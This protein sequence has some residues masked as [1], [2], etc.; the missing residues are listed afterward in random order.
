MVG[1]LGDPAEPRA[2]PGHRPRRPPR[3]WPTSARRSCACGPGSL[4]PGG[5]PRHGLGHPRPARL[6]AHAARGRAFHDGARARR[7]RRRG[8]PRAPAPRA[9]LSRA[10]PSGSG[11]TSS[12]SRSTS[13]TPPCSRRSPSP[14]SAIQSPRRLAARPTP[15]G[16][17]PFRLVVG[18]ARA[19][20]ARRLRRL[21]GRARRACGGCVFRRFASEDALAR[22]LAARRGG[23]LRRRSAPSG[24]PSCARSAA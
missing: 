10:T 13:R 8:E 15:V 11:R 16:T 14:S 4:R 9:R 7:R 5:R 12:R 6:D 17:G 24:P 18:Q 23:R 1:T 20:R 2:A 19:R 21:L 22:A 3:S